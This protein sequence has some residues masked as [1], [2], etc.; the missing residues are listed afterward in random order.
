MQ[1]H[2]PTDSHPV[3]LEAAR[4]RRATQARRRTGA[5]GQQGWAQPLQFDESG[6]P[7][8]RSMPSFGERVRRLL[9]GD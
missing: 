6:F 3:A 9:F 5:A 7:I 2:A 8:P 4:M 1:R